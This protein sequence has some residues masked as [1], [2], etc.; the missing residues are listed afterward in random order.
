MDVRQMLDHHIES[1]ADVTVAAVPV[2]IADAPAFGVVGVDDAGAMASFIEKP[3]HPV[4]IPG[5]PGTAM[6]SMGNT[7]W[8]TAALIDE[9]NRA[10]AAGAELDFGANILP[11][12]LGRR[13]VAVYDFRKNEIPG[14]HERERGYWRDVGTIGSYYA[15]NLDLIDIHPR[16]DLYNPRWP[17]RTWARPLPPAKFVFSNEREARVGMAVDSLVSEGSIISGGRIT[18]SLIGPNVRVNSFSRVEGS[19]VHDGVVVGRRSHLRRAIVDKGIAIPD[20]LEIGVDH[21][22]DLENGLW[23][24]APEDLVVVPKG[25]RFPSGAAPSPTD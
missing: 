10:A 4:A 20:G 19:I 8:N 24:F 22:R 23:V 13:P 21:A 12:L 3:E 25:H 18:G 1:Q 5:A 11:S 7:I 9:L 15:A 17:V 6:A 14:Q 2:P 16:L